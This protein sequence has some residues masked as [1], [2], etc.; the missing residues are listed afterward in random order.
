M[1]NG[2]LFVSASAITG[3]VILTGVT[4]PAGPAG[5]A[6]PTGPTGPAGA[7]GTSVEIQGELSDPGLLPPTGNT[8]GDGYLI[9][10]ELWVWTGAAWTNV[11]EIQGAPG[12]TG[13]AGPTGSKGDKGDPG[14]IGPAGGQGSQGP[15]GI[16]GVK[17]DTGTQG[18]SGATGPQ[19]PVGPQGPQGEQ[20]PQGPAGSGGGGGSGDAISTAFTPTGGVQASNVQA[21]IAEVD[22]EK[23]P[24]TVS[25][26]TTLPLTGGGDLSSNR[27]IGINAFTAT[28][29]GAVPNPA[30]ATGRFLMDNGT[31]GT[32]GLTGVTVKDDGSGLG[33]GFTSLNFGNGLDVASAGIEASV[34]LDL[35]EYT[36]ANL[37]QAKVASLSTDLANRVT[38]VQ[39]VTGIWSGTQVAY[40]AIGTKTPTV[41]YL[42]TG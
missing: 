3:E 33:S 39:G 18:P 42:I 31:W 15:Q 38:N 12:A 37:P 11:G 8:N 36:G 23:V 5:P 29:A 27:T 9:N 35:A 30:G 16:P 32:G 40:N 4:G 17:G 10:G 24:K 7:P 22:S 34:V 1:S 41:L 21:A 2:Q 28:S 19:G 6:G 25:I 26:A 14:T 13:P 20:G